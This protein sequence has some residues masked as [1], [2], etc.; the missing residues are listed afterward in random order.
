MAIVPLQF[1]RV[2]NALTMGLAQ[3][4]I[5]RTQQSLLD[6][7][8]QL[9]TGKRYV[10]LQIKETGV[11]NVYVAVTTFGDEG[12]EKPKLNPKELKEQNH[13]ELVSMTIQPGEEMIVGQRL[14]EIL[15]DA[16]KGKAA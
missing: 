16:R 8:N 11:Q 6:V 15:N 13:I 4:S 3:R 12:V 9:T 5:A 1:A 2:S 10:R 7:Q 14:R